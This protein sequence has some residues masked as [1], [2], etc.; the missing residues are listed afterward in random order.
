[1]IC[2]GGFFRLEYDLPNPPTFSYIEMLKA[3]STGEF[4]PIFF[5]WYKFVGSLAHLAMIISPDSDGFR[6]TSPRNISVITGLINRCCRLMLANVALS[7]QGK[8]GETTVI[9]DRC[10]FESAVKISWLCSDPKQEYFDRFVNDGLRADVEFKQQIEENIAQRGRVLL[11]EKRM[12]NSI[13]NY[14]KLSGTTEDSV[15]QSKRMPKFNQLM[16]K[17]G[18]NK[19]QHLV[20]Q[21]LGSHHVH[22]TWSSLLTHYLEPDETGKQLVLRDHDCPTDTNQYV[23]TIQAVLQAVTD[24]IN[25]AFPSG[26][27]GKPLIDLFSDTYEEIIT[28]FEEASTIR[29]HLQSSEF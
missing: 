9:V 6:K 17:T 7:H 15:N 4:E 5:E 3:R 22:G 14:L 29:D 13:N 12:L 20:R 1:M 25:Y 16:D 11:I 28:L 2:G 8:F 18:H 19:L 21:K 26:K 23:A 27:T 24:Y 10:I